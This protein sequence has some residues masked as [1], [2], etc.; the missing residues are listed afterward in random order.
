MQQSS[1]RAL[2]SGATLFGLLF[3]GGAATAGDGGISEGEMI[4]NSCLACH[5][6]GGQGAESMPPLAGWDE[7]ALVEVMRDFREGRGDPT[8]MDRHATGYT[9]EQLRAVA[10]YLAAMDQ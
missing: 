1:R 8:V 2:L 4:A 5:G 3:G 10:A 6:P 7:E 9:D